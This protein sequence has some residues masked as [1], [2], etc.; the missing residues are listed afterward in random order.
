MSPARP[1]S[2]STISHSTVATPRASS[3]A[4]S[5]SHRLGLGSV[6]SHSSTG[7]F[8]SSSPSL[9][10]LPADATHIN[11]APDSE[12][13]IAQDRTKT[14][15]LRIPLPLKSHTNTATFGPVSI[16]LTS[17]KSK[18]KRKL[19]ISGIAV[20]DDRRVEAVKKWCEVSVFAF[21]LKEPRV[22]LDHSHLV[23]SIPSHACV[24]AI[25]TSTSVAQ[26]LLTL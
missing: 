4:P 24:V 6:R 8:S 14:S 21:A 26:K 19:V 23:K 2:A 20:D 22:Y 7:F 9:W 11:D 1:S 25:F 15:T 13:V 17:P 12:K 3:E 5:V 10:S 18:K 16:M